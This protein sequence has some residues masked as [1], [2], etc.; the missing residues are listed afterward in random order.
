MNVNINR[1]GAGSENLNRF[2][3]NLSSSGSSTQRKPNEKEKKMIALIFCFL[4]ST[5]ICDTSASESTQLSKEWV[6]EVLGGIEAARLVAEKGGF[7]FLGQVFP[8]SDLYH[9]KEKRISK[10]SVDEAEN[11]LSSISN[12]KSFSHQTVH[13]VRTNQAQYILIYTVKTN[14]FSESQK[15]FL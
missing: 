10:R 8:D 3:S 12:V 14:P 15:R 1:L 11:N 6:V 9:L 7:E 2:T 5:Q 4:L 13:K